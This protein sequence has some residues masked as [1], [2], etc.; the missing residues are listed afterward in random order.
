MSSRFPTQEEWEKKCDQKARFDRGPGSPRRKVIV[1]YLSKKEI[2]E[3]LDTLPVWEA[4]DVVAA[5]KEGKKVEVE[6]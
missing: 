5:L 1:N 6:I 4:V 3:W 2:A